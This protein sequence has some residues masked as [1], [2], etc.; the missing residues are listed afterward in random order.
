MKEQDVRHRIE[1]FLKRTA[2][3]MIIPASAGLSLGLSGY[4]SDVT[5]PYGPPML[6]EAG[7]DVQPVVSHGALFC[8]WMLV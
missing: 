3:D 7:A 6:P 8:G 4:G 5:P 1:S 2:R